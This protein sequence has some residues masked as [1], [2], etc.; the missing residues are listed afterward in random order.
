MCIRCRHVVA[1][2]VVGLHGIAVHVH[3]RWRKDSLSQWTDGNGKHAVCWQTR[4]AFKKAYGLLSVSAVFQ[5]RGYFLLVYFLP[6]K[7]NAG[8]RTGKFFRC[9]EHVFALHACGYFPLAEG[10]W[11]DWFEKLVVPFVVF[12]FFWRAEEG[13]CYRVMVKPQFLI[14]QCIHFCVG[15]GHERLRRS[16]F[17][18]KYGS[19]HVGD[20]P[21]KA[22]YTIFF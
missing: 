17:W 6:S 18:R 3:N 11:F 20:W 13:Y 4:L 10:E 5:V 12:D 7:A 1:G 16:V 14:Q 9:A 22:A 2:K 19:P 8:T 15:K 21:S